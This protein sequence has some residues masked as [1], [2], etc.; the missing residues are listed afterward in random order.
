MDR[1]IIVG[2]EVVIVRASRMCSVGDVH[3]VICDSPF[4]DM[5]MLSSR[6]IVY[7]SYV[8]LAPPFWLTLTLE[9]V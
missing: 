6:H 8:E 2:D 7:R 5:L 1:E 3:T 4:S 9:D